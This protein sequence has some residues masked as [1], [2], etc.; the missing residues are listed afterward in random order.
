MIILIHF[1]AIIGILLLAFCF[2]GAKKAGGAL[3]KYSLLLLFGV[4]LL[5]RVAAAALSKGFGSD[6]ACFAAWAE[7]IYALGPGGFYSPDVFTDYPPGYMYILWVVGAV[8]NLFGLEYYSAA[9]LILLR[10]PSIACDLL[11][12]ILIFREAKKR[13][14]ETTGFFLCLAYLLNPVIVLNSSVWGQVDTVFTLAVIC[15][16]LYLIRGRMLP[17][18]TA[19]GLGVLIKPQTLIFAPVLLAGIIDRVFRKDFSAKKLLT[20]LMQGLGVIGG[21]LLLVLPFGVSNVWNQYFST[22]GSYPYAA[23]NACNLWGLFGLN[24]VSQDN[25]FLGV[26]YRIIGAAVIVASV[27]FVLYLSLRL[28]E[29]NE[30]YPF[31]AAILILTI[32]TFSV[33]MHERYMYPG[34]LLLLFSYIYRP[35]GL[36]FLCYGGF[37]VMHFYNTAQVLFFYDPGNYDGKAPII[38]LTSAG[39]LICAVLLY[40]AAGKVY[41]SGSGNVMPAAPKKIPWTFSPGNQDIR[42][43]RRGVPLRAADYIIMLVFTGVYSCFALYDLG[44]RQAPSTAYDMAAYGEIIELD[45]GTEIPAILSYYIAPWQDRT[46]ALEGRESGQTKWSS[47][48]DVNLKNVFT[49]QETEI[50]S[51]TSV[52]RLRSKDNQASLLEL[53]FL[54]EDGRVITPVNAEQYPALFD[55]AHLFPAAST[56]RNSMY[57]DEVYHGRTAY[58]FLHGLTTYENT[59]P[60]LGKIFISL[61]VLIFGMCP[62]GWRIAGTLFGIV[63]V[64]VLYL[65]GKRISESTPI[66]ALAC[67]MFTFDFMHFTQTRLA[68]I[69]VYVTFFVILMYYF[70]YQYSQLSF[71]DTPLRRTFLPLGAC[72]V[73]MG[74]GIAC[75]WTGIYAGAGLAVIFF[76]LLF[77]RYLEYLYAKETPARI[78]G[79]IPHRYV[80]E[81]FIPNTVKT[82]LFCIVF[83]VV[84]PALIY[85]LSYLPFVDYTPDLGLVERMLK[86]QETMFNYH[87]KLSAEHPYSSWWYEWPTIIRPIWYYSRTVSSVAGEGIRQ[88]VR[89][90]CNLQGIAVAVGEGGLREGIS[91]F[92]NPAV[93]WPGIPAAFYMVYLVL[94][95]K[96][97]TAAFLLVGYLAQYLPWFFVTRITFIYHYFPSVVFI[98]MMIIH[99]L[100]QWKNKLGKGGLIAVTAA[101][102]SLVIVL[103]LM[104]YPVLSGEPVEASYVNKFLRWFNSW[105]LASR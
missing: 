87:S 15:M 21:M 8:R 82:I 100:A 91:A 42:P 93:W 1:F 102:G 43:S 92:G 34:L 59:H 23:V 62:L 40:Y 32:F 56:F 12:G 58:E 13:L 65:F 74:L 76:A 16:C 88:V 48:G 45:F 61:G 19:F 9:H 70:M 41:L 2:L 80:A 53:V 50:A 39:M 64:P 51:G 79:G 49:W 52:I 83:F 97:R 77:K 81:I 35:S 66:A 96:D 57:F 27:A 24:W 6:T 72:G 75:K 98:V 101:Y 17:A 71:Y 14:S 20:N 11:C 5:V 69:D 33:R 105:V 36:T 38:L 90:G 67:A 103:F 26:P 95:K 68:T 31:L 4:S 99:G 54:T 60:P 46:F 7:R 85:L 86:N 18:Y 10:L 30:K 29:E 84:V 47:F 78:S 44:D 3:P 28:K 89:L 94:S 73:C 104:F 63:M 55:E 37:S 22:V 25:T